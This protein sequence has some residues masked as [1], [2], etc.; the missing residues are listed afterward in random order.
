LTL[1]IA[2]VFAMRVY[3]MDVA[4]RNVK[5]FGVLREG[6][7]AIIPVWEYRFPGK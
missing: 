6:S 5:G 3:R 2:T 1:L 7:W 4:G